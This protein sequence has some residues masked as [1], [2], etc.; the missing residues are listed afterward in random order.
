MGA[1]PAGRAEGPST[2]GGG[3]GLHTRLRGAV[4]AGCSGAVVA[5]PREL[6]DSGSG[7]DFLP[8]LM[9]GAVAGSAV[10][11][12]SPSARRRGRREPP[13]LPSPPHPPPPP[14]ERRP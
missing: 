6:L 7:R 12:A 13:A 4:A 9:A 3:T 5:G 10:G 8:S 1:P 2:S 14:P 11:F